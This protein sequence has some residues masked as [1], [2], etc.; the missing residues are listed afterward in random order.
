M[1]GAPASGSAG[2]LGLCGK[3]PCVPTGLLLMLMLWAGWRA[4]EEGVLADKVFQRL[5]EGVDP[6]SMSPRAVTRFWVDIQK[7]TEAAGHK[8]N[9]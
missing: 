8:A 3:L 9:T 4:N 1:R 7:L 6:E 5:Q 2:L